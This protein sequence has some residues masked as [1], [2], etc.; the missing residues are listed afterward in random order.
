MGGQTD[1]GG[2]RTGEKTGR[3]GGRTG[4]QGGRGNHI[5]NQGNIK[6]Q[7]DN[8]TDGS[9]HEDDRNVNV[10]NGNG[11]NGCTYKDFVACKLKEFD[12]K[13]GAVAYICWVEKME[14]VT[15]GREAAV[16]TT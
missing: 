10:G 15:R 3:V 11:R 8:V 14:V 6:S 13:G 12:V 1:R 5:S 9:I 16:G 4:D 2:G 7:N